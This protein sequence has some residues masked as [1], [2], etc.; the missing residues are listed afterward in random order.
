MAA[1]ANQGLKTKKRFS[2]FTYL[3]ETKQELKRVS[4]PTKKELL[5]NTGVVLT[6]VISSTILVWALDSVL[7]GAL[8]LILK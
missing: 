2:L 7:S 6:V 3:K 1:Q 4:W 5:K 8:K